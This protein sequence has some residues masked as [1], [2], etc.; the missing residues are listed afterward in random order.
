MFLDI[1]IVYG[2][3]LQGITMGE[4]GAII[5]IIIIIYGR[6]LLGMLGK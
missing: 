4:I 1:P 3:F 2:Y 6:A 5:I